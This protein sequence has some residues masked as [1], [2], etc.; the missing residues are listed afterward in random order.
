MA[1]P[2]ASPEEKQRILESLAK[3]RRENNPRH[4]SK[5]YRVAA[6]APKD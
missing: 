4:Q 5:R 2:D 1:W 6:E 3:R